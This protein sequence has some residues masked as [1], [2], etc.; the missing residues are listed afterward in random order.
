MTE[1]NY[2]S[3]RFAGCLILDNSFLLY[4]AGGIVPIGLYQSAGFSLIGLKAL[5]GVVKT[6]WVGDQIVPSKDTLYDNHRLFIFSY[7]INPWNRLSV[8]ANVNFYMQ[9]NFGSP[10][11]GLSADL[12]LSYRLFRHP[13]LG[14]HVIGAN[15][16]NLFSPDTK[17]K[18]FFLNAMN[19]KFSWQA[20]I[21]EKRIDI[22][23]DADL[24]DIAAAKK[25]F[26]GG[27]PKKI[28]FDFSGR[29]GFWI[30]RIL[31]LYLQFGEEYYGVTGGVN[32]PSVNNGRDL[33]VLYQFMMI[34]QGDNTI[35]QTAY[36][37][38]DIGKHREEIYARKMARLASIGPGDLY[39]RARTLYSEG[40]YWDAFFIFGRIMVEYPDFFK[41]DWVRLFMGLCQENLDMKEYSTENL[42]LSKKDYPRSVIVPYADLALMRLAYRD[43]NGSAVANQFA[44]L[45]T[46]SVPDS[47]KFHAYYYMAE[48]H[49]RDGDY[50]KAIQLF[51]L[52]PES[53]PE[54]LFAQHSLAVAYALSN[55]F[56]MAIEALDNV[57][58]GK[59][60]TKEQEEVINRSFVF[61]GYIFYEG[62]GGQE[63]ALS[64][65]VSALRKIPKSSY[66]YEDA[67][68]GQAWTALRASQWADCMASC[69]ELSAL[70]KKPVIKYEAALLLG[71]CY[72]VDKKYVE[73][74]SVLSP[75]NDEIIKLTAPG[76]S[77]MSN[78]K[79][80]YDNNRGAYYEVAGKANELALTSQT[81][82]SIAQ[83]DSLKPVQ[84]DY[85]TQLKNFYIYSDE[86]AR[87]SFFARNIDNVK[88]DIEYALAKAEKMISQKDLDKIKQKAVEKTGE[89]DDEMKKLEEELK[90][91]EKK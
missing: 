88:S 30:L 90:Q 13:V 62:L 38:A 37:R 63:R 31:N 40:K 15:V 84:Q 89:I 77:E 10:I 51:P 42:N 78:K 25:E 76:A 35:S 26:T 39:N 21:W 64:K 73:A 69:N 74:V 3:L 27:N 61:L 71:Y 59:P 83:I 36:I 9:D 53:H 41:N 6:D 19:L 56:T 43:N 29:V 70:T 16:Q 67:L 14:D 72:M 33:Q 85:Y 80:D 60:K 75:A 66:Y 91:L 32:I 4:E 81:S 22:G 86:F 11:Y 47:L 87:R 1:E 45:N 7:A 18:N 8:G 17:F 2:L 46:S 5:E 23:I 65:A 52:I 68:L 55:N 48:S 28:E 54:Y 58:Q 57:C 79:L 24:K 12:A 20:K 44:R 82:Y 49:L 50:Q 34:P